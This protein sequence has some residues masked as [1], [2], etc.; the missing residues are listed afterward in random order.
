[1]MNFEQITTLENAHT[2]G[3]YS[4]RPMDLVRGNGVE[5]FDSA[6]RRYLDM[7]SGQG[8]ALLGHAHPRVAEAIATQAQTL[9]TCPEIFYNDRRAELY[10]EL[11]KHLPIQLD[12]MFLCNSG[13]EANEAALKVA[14]ILTNRPKVIS[15]MRGFHGRTLGALSLTWNKKYRDSFEDWTI[16]VTHVPYND[17]DAMHNA[18]DDQTGAVVLEAIQGEGGVNPASVAYLQ[19][20]RQLCTERGALLVFDEVQ[21]GLGRTGRWFAFEHAEIIPDIIS[22][23][24]GIAGGVPMGA[25]IWNG[26]YGMLPSASH[27]STFGGNPLACAASIATLQT[28]EQEQL[29]QHAHELGQWALES[30]SQLDSP[31]IREVRGRGMMIGIELK[32]RVTP[33]LMSLQEQGILALPA[34]NNVLRLLPPLIVTQPQL[35]ETI[36]AI[37]QALRAL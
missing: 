15:A 21:A 5:V 20:V 30:L 4:N 6:G 16:P 36:T 8:V 27:G 2:S 24:K 7:T 31:H 18:I 32:S 35:E 17:L 25:V 14:R 19:A 26:T 13:A 23:G 12:R 34:G 33:V 22:L 3:A 11:S 29:P 37:E 9:I 28:L 1:M 10:A